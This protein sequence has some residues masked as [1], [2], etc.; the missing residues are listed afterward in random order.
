LIHNY[1][2]ALEV[3]GVMQFVHPGCTYRSNGLACAKNQSTNDFYLN[4]TMRLIRLLLAL[5]T[6]LALAGC[7]NQA[8]SASN[9]IVKNLSDEILNQDDPERVLASFLAPRRTK[10]AVFVALL[11][12]ANANWNKAGACPQD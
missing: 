3:S 2:H 1:I 11:S 6:L 5:L 4:S 9:R 12:L 10:C 8:S 7:A